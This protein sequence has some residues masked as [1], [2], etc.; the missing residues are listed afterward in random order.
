M[1]Q[2]AVVG[3]RF[4]LG[5]R[6]GQGSMGTVY[7]GFDTQ[8][9]EQV[10]IKLLRSETL[11]GDPTSAA[12][13]A[14]EGEA[15]RRLN[16]PSIV[17]VLAEVQEGRQHYL[18][19]ELVT[20]GSLAR[21]LHDTSAPLPVA[22]VLSIA[23]D[24][25]DALARAH[26]LGIVHRDLKP[27]NVLLAQD[28]TP[29][30]TD[31]GVAYLGGEEPLSSAPRIVGTLP[32][33]S[34][35]MVT[36]ETIDA[37]TDIWSFGVLLFEMLSR[38]QPF[39]RD[40]PAATLH[41]IL[42][43]EPPD[44]EEL[45]PDCPLALV[46]L[47][48]R[49]LEKSRN[50]R[51]ASI[52]QVGAALEGMLESDVALDDNAAWKP[53]TELSWNETACADVDKT[54]SSTSS[55]TLS[56]VDGAAA[57][58]TSERPAEGMPL[59]GR[60]TELNTLTTLLEDPKVRLVTVVG[61]GG[62][63]KSRLAHEGAR[64]LHKCQGD[65]R[66]ARAGTRRFA[67]GVCFVELAPLASPDLILSAVAGALGLYFDPTREPKAQLFRFLRAKQL[68]IVMDNFEHLLEA[69]QLVSE[70]LLNAPDVKVLATS[71]ERLG[72]SHESVLLLSG[73]TF[74]E[75]GVPDCASDFSAVQLFVQTACRV[76]L[77][78]ELTPDSTTHVAKICQ[79]VAGSPLGIVLAASWANLL[80]VAE[81]ATE[82]AADFD[83]LKADLRDVPER[84][85]SLRAVFDQ[86]FRLLAPTE[87][88]AFARL[89]VFRGGFSRESAQSIAGASLR[90]LAALVNK[91]LVSRDPLSG[92]YKMHELLR[93]YA[94]VKLHANPQEH[95]AVLDRHAHFHLEF[96][97]SR[98]ARLRTG[99]PQLAAAEIDVEIDNVRAAWQRILS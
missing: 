91:S 34:P 43:A 13:F 75:P 77:D 85:Q 94:M 99:N 35:E 72:L 87:Q 15:L 96:L 22:R 78:F 6:I 61:P 42:N 41:A 32:Y 45:R 5:E 81:I 19:M 26:R 79:L 48:Y 25:S 83:F 70:I 10:A 23:L 57:T 7:R 58:G 14:R 80:S 54:L 86:S 49:M 51:L 24:L 71:R 98:E 36:S 30:L 27:A 63:G 76:Q 53:R 67:Q 17:K 90:T 52:R 84:Q 69:T 64:L 37:R 92:R 33:I 56:R 28:G 12:R 74:P 38:T 46:D 20:G 50:L 31:F 40:H 4:E 89:A 82:I 59:I 44:L 55:Q 73:M 16:H 95:D 47:I 18:V 39:T 65:L 29:R 3:S 68:L 2:A 11:L 9:R 21:L 97:S 66:Q 8:T 93:Q 1:N 62:I 60:E 88:Q